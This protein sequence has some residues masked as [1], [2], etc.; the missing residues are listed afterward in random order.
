VCS[1]LKAFINKVKSVLFS[2][3]TEDELLLVSIAKLH[4][5]SRDQIVNV[6]LRVNESKAFVRHP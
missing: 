1:H 3:I 5:T 6:T 4:N 2:F